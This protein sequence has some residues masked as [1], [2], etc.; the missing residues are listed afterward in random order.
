MTGI[1][2]ALLTTPQ[3][4]AASPNGILLA[5]IGAI[6]AGFRRKHAIGGWLF[7]FIWNVFSS[8]GFTILQLIQD[9]RSYTPRPWANSTMYLAML[10][11]AVPRITALFGIAGVCIMLLRTM[12]W[13]WATLLRTGLVTFFLA[14]AVGVAVDVAFFPSYVATR[15]ATALSALPFLAYTL[16]S[17]RFA[18]VFLTHDWDG[19]AR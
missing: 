12:E 9:W 14:C 5:L 17:R 19:I 16:Y 4:A 11:S 7:Y 13:R 10:L 6:V 8:A 1:P 2:L 15:M 3:H 18:K